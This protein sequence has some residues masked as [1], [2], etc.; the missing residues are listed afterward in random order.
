MSQSLTVFSSVRSGSAGFA[1]IIFVRLI[2]MA[3]LLSVKAHRTP[4]LHRPIAVGIKLDSRLPKVVTD[5]RTLP[6]YHPELE[7]D[8]EHLRP[9][10]SIAAT[11]PIMMLHSL[12][13]MVY[14]RPLLRLLRFAIADT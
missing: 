7:M 1:G 4:F 2:S 5:R 6:V 8:Q 10:V 3:S 11:T 14:L 9:S 13:V 12:T